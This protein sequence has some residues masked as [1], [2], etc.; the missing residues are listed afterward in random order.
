[1]FV[2]PTAIILPFKTVFVDGS[3]PSLASY[4]VLTA[5]IWT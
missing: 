1:M 5:I 3:N 4:V 2:T